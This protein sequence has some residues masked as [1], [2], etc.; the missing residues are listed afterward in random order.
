MVVEDEPLFRQMLLSQLANDSEIEVVGEADTG[1]QAVALAAQTDPEVCLMD[2]ELGSGM[3]GIQAG[4][5][6]KAAKPSTGIVL[7][8]NHKAKQFIVTLSGWSYLLKQNVRDLN[9][10]VRAIKGAAW[11][12][13]V[14]DPQVTESLTPRPGSVLGQL[15]PRDVKI[16]E[17]MAQGF[18]ERAIAVDMMMSIEDLDIHLA[19]IFNQLAIQTHSDI[20]P[21]V[22]VIRLYLDQT[23]G[24]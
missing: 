12:M 13:I 9:T 6:I 20:D 3:T 15:E 21:R 4:H 22:A 17:L 14:I 8:S 18:T 16:I 19:K 2:I 7:L 5:A 10:V 24:L 11:G 23:K 1:E